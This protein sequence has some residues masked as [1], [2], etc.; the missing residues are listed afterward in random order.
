[1][2]TV[3]STVVTATVV[4]DLQLVNQQLLSTMFQDMSEL[5]S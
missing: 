4:I 5:L 1:M 3:S 2:L